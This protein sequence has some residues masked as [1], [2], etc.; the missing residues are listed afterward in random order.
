M[1]VQARYPQGSGQGVE[2]PSIEAF[3]FQRGI[4]LTT[5]KKK[6]KPRKAEDRNCDTVNKGLDCCIVNLKR[7]GFHLFDL[8]SSC[9]SLNANM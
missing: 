7:C 3:N 8:F 4:C 1:E 9:V 5:A 2:I 6:V